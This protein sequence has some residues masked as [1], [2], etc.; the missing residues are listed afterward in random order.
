MPIR[1]KERDGDMSICGDSLIGE[2]DLYQSQSGGAN[3][4]SPLHLS[5]LL[6]RTMQKAHA[7]RIFIKK[8]YAHRAVPIS[9]C[10]GVFAPSGKYHDRCVGAISFGKPASPSLCVGACGKE[11]SKRIYE[12]NR[13]WLSD[14]CPRNSESMVIGRALKYIKISHP[15]WILVSYADTKQ[16]HSGIIYRATNWIYTGLSDARPCGDY[17]TENGKHSRHAKKQGLPNIP[18]SRKHRYFYFFNKEDIKL[19]KY[20]IISWKLEERFK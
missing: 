8:H 5:D 6:I 11:N 20:P 1:D 12:L 14:E 4:T 15:D 13:L 2:Q 18:R 17:A 3:P 19:L 16:G 7:N 10:Y 9:E